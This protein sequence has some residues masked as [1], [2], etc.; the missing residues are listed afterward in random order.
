MKNYYL[1]DEMSRLFYIA[2]S[3]I[4]AVVCVTACN[5]RD[6]LDRIDAAETVVE[7]CPDSA[8][9]LLQE[10]DPAQLH[11]WETPARYALAYTAAQIKCGIHV[12]DDS[13]IR[14]ALD[15]YRPDSTVE[16]MR[17]L[18]YLALIYQNANKLPAATKHYSDA[19][20]IAINLNDHFFLGLIYRGL[21]DVYDATSTS[22]ESVRYSLKSLDSFLSHNDS[23]YIR[24]AFADLAN[25]YTTIQDYEKSMNAANQALKMSIDSNDSVCAIYTLNIMASC[26]MS[27]KDYAKSRDIYLRIKDCYHDYVNASLWSRL[28]LCC[29]YLSET[30]SCRFYMNKA[31]QAISTRHDSI[32]YFC[33]RYQISYLE[34]NDRDAMY[35]LENA[36]ALQN[37][38]TDEVFSQSAAIAQRDYYREDSL[39]T[40]QILQTTYQRIIYTAIV[41]ILVIS[42]IV[43]F[44]RNRWA[45]KNFKISENARLIL[46]L[47]CKYEN[48]KENAEYSMQEHLAQI[49]K[50]NIEN[51]ILTENVNK[52]NNAREIILTMFR[53]QIVAVEQVNKKI[54]LLST[55]PNTNKKLAKID[56]VIQEAVADF[57]PND[58][59]F[60]NL[61]SVVNSMADDIMV[62]IRIDFPK[63]TE[64]DYRIL[65]CFYAGFSASEVALF[66]GEDI[67]NVY[68]IKSRLKKRITESDSPNKII[69]LDKINIKD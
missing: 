19:E 38:I 14:V 40:K 41:L 44:I 7:T 39:K 10:V 29:F 2:I 60:Q 51:D 15:Y 12:D 48:F 47:S 30:D 34:G 32:E 23:K 64:R 13:L 25:C 59:T 21:A 36:V 49:E 61:E 20:K 31:S 62:K 6:I 69:F 8:L 4:T 57:A 53:E 68:R 63:L 17:A 26:Y 65:C 46:E 1:C 11:G 55:L 3:L 42:I 52:S 58:E 28:G 27:S 9:A 24:Y 5:S 54:Q 56:S 37:R 45:N 66:T 67:N 35:N 43:L 50:S 16:H 22:D 18:Y 33:N